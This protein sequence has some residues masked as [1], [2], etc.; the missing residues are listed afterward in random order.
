MKSMSPKV[1]NLIYQALDAYGEAVFSREDIVRW[2]EGDFESTLREGLLVEA[3]PADE[4]VCPGCEEACLE[5]VEFVRGDKPEETRAYVICGQRDDIGRVQIPM[6]MLD[7]WAVNR[8]QLG[9]LFAQ[10]GH[11]GGGCGETCESRAAMPE[12]LW[13]AEMPL[14]DK[15]PLSLTLD[16]GRRLMEWWEAIV[17]WGENMGLVPTYVETLGEHLSMIAEV[18]GA[19]SAPLDAYALVLVY[20]G[21]TE[22]NGA[23]QFLQQLDRLGR[24]Q[25]IAE[26]QVQQAGKRTYAV[27]YGDLLRAKW[28]E[29]G[30]M[31]GGGQA[32]SKHRTSSLRKPSKKAIACYRVHITLGQP[33][34]GQ[35]AQ[36]LA[37]EWR[38]P[39]HQG[40]VSRWLREVD[41]WLKAGKVLP[42]IELADNRGRIKSIAVDPSRL[43]LGNRTDHLRKPKRSPL[44]E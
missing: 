39:V 44:Q 38:M 30:G 25:I 2:P 27:T 3:A 23:P 12:E 37:K 8:F 15:D 22:Q 40:T 9:R 29:R 6:E 5:D 21:P 1:L 11:N 33:A 35:T 10:N 42:E 4:V 28:A 17:G 26:T 16:E 43:E 36:A 32:Y 14:V 41:A 7:R 31:E 19:D 24:M 18:L 13:E 34:Q 20:A